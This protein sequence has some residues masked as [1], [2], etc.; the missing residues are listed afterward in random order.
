VHALQCGQG[1]K[2][3]EVW[4]DNHTPCEFGRA[5]LTK[6]QLAFEMNSKRSRF[7]YCYEEEI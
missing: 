6:N 4:R 5:S 2:M 3:P 7:Y 1:E